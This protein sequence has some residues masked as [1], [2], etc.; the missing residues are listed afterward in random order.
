M[1]FEKSA[2][3]RIAFCKLFIYSFLFLSCNRTKHKDTSTPIVFAIQPY[4]FQDKQQLKFL[5]DA[6]ETYYHFNV[7]LLPYKMLP[8]EAYYE[9]RNRYK[10]DILIRIL[11]NTKPDSVNYIIGITSKDISTKK[12]TY[13]DFG[14]MGLGFCPGKS[15]MVSVFRLKT[16]NKYLFNE[17]LA[18]VALHEIGHNLG[19][20]H[21][22]TN[23]CF[24]HAAEASIKQ[25]DAEKLDMCSKC[26][27]MINL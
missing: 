3:Y 5:K 8:Q 10:A 7:I 2:T 12:G 21:C 16:T 27:K 18:K 9:P 25:V 14:I 11:R 1:N 20:P 4:D 13:A 17:R 23:D 22:T 19:L 26:K 15:S 24:M 6:I